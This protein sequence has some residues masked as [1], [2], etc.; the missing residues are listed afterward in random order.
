[1]ISEKIETN[2]VSPVIVPAYFLEADSRM[3]CRDRKPNELSS[4]TVLRRLTSEIQE[5]KVA[6]ICGT[7]N[8]TEGC[9]TE[10]QRERETE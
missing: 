8:Q 5:G 10:R 3:Q 7:E 9:C 1:M 4:L 2:K 6:R